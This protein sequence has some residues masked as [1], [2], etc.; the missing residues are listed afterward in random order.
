LHPEA[1]WLYPE[2]FCLQAAVFLPLPLFFCLTAA[3]RRN[4]FG[5][6]LKILAGRTIMPEKT[7]QEQI[8]ELL[9]V[10]FAPP[11]DG[12]EVQAL[13]KALPGYQ[14]IVD[15]VSQLAQ[16]HAT[17]LHLSPAVLADLDQGLAAVKHLEPIEQLLERLHQSIYHQR[18]Q[19]TSRCMEGLFSVSRR[20]REFENACPEIKEQAQYLFDFLKA[21]R[22]GPKKEKGADETKPTA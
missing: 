17:T 10:E 11:L 16:Q 21:F 15:D 22:P 4:N 18:L 5:V 14:A 8:A 1:A 2:Y 20:V 12:D 19:A 9:N 3:A 13:L 6:S 7:I